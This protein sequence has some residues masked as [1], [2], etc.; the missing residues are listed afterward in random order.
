MIQVRWVLPQQREVRDATTTNYKRNS[1][2]QR[3]VLF[4]L[5]N[6]VILSK[7]WMRHSCFQN[8][9]IRIGNA[10]TMPASSILISYHSIV[11]MITNKKLFLS[12]LEAKNMFLIHESRKK[13]IN[14]SVYTP[15]TKTLYSTISHHEKSKTKF[16]M[17]QNNK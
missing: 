15:P 17:G 5:L 2:T 16:N 8:W 10:N 12:F 6:Y 14:S 3:K 9:W 7:T 1:A 4:S 13:T 11:N